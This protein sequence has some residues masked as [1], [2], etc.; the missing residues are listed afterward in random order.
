M[1]L[2]V[3]C[4]IPLCLYAFSVRYVVSHFVSYVCMSFP[5]CLSLFMY[6]CCY[7]F[8]FFIYLVTYCV[9]YACMYFVSCLFRDV[10]PFFTS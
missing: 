1:S 10:C 2:G 9:R 7:V 4:C 3:P 6:V 8:M 5:R